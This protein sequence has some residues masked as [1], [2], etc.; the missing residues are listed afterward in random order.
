MALAKKNRQLKRDLDAD[1]A[2]ADAYLDLP[3]DIDLA[4]LS[5]ANLRDQVRA[6]DEK[7]QAAL[8]GFME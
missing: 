8:N 1:K 4:K 7:I 3:P 6:A 5:L 2:T